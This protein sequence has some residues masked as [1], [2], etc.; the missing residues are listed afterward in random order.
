MPDK[1]PDRSQVKSRGPMGVQVKPGGETAVK[2]NRSA[3]Y[4][5]VDATINDRA[6][7]AHSDKQDEVERLA[8]CQNMSIEGE[9]GSAC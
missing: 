6:E 2:Q 5:D 3:V 7:E 8:T 9:R 4:K 1:P